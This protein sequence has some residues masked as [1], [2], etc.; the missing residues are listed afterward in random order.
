MMQYVRTARHNCWQHAVTASIPT[1]GTSHV[2]TLRFRSQ[3]CIKDVSLIVQLLLLLSAKCGT[4]HHSC[5]LLHSYTYIYTYIHACMHQGLKGDWLVAVISQS[6]IDDWLA[7]LPSRVTC[8]VFEESARKI[9]I[10]IFKLFSKFVNIQ[11]LY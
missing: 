9:F 4:Q 8:R 5:Y 11:H 7:L 3:I 2:H 10:Y 6:I 1:V